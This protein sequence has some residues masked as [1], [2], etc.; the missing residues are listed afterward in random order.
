MSSR[1][2]ELRAYSLLNRF[3][4]AVE[5]HTSVLFSILER[6]P[7]TGSARP[8]ILLMNILVH[9][10]IDKRLGVF[11]KQ[12]SIVQEMNKPALV[13]GLATMLLIAIAMALVRQQ[14]VSG[15]R[16]IVHGADVNGAN[17]TTGANG[18]NGNNT[19]GAN[20]ITTTALMEL[21]AMLRRI[22]V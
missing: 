2:T 20:G 22:P 4:Q 13:I 16:I 7:C 18:A 5:Q 10:Y 17:G 19:N 12:F 15:V 21:A 11:V 14:D 8:K 3:K 6:T 1:L 9:E